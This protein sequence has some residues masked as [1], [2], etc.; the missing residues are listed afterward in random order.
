MHG[1]LDNAATFDPLMQL[2][3]E[4]LSFLVI[5]LPGHGF[6]SH[7]P[8]GSMYHY[9]EDLL[10]IRH[11]INRHFKWKNV[12]LMGHSMGSM[13]SFM[14]AAFYP[15]EVKKV[16]GFDILRP[17]ALNSSKFI[18]TGGAQIDKFIDLT[19]SKIEP[20]EYAP[21]DIIA[22]QIKA[23]KDSITKESIK[24]L[25]TRGAFQS[26][27]NK[28]LIGL[29]RDIRLRVS[30]LHS[31]P[32]EFLV[33]LSAR[34]KCQVLNIKFKNG[35]YYEKREY[36]EQT[37]NILRQSAKRLEYYEVEGTHHA[38]LNNPENVAQIVAHF[39]SS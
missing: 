30:L 29:T 2:L 17:V 16:I 35:P 18:E 31:L 38:H 5:D 26:K 24:I 15:L 33:E 20:P 3:P 11:I 13:L 12:T 22:R 10:T 21:D 23:T 37:L 39:L 28:E 7:Y 34:I 27:K 6:S 32:H 36:Y 19:N 1:W 8:R 14:Y 9:T 25:L 4:H